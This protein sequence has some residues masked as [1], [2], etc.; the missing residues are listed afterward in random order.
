MNRVEYKGIVAYH[1]GYYV[2]DMIDELDM[3]QEEIS[4][5]LDATPKHV[6]DLINGKSKLTEEFALKLATVFG[7]S[8]QLWLNL[9][10]RYIEKVLEI[11]KIQ[12]LEVECEIAKQIDYSFFVDLGLLPYK[13]KIEEK[14]E[15]LLKYFKVATLKVLSR[16]DFLVQYK[17]AV[18]NIND[19]NVINANAW[20]QSAM[21]I[22]WKIDTKPFDE[23]RLKDSLVEIRTMTVK[24]PID[25]V[26]KLKNILAECGIA[27]VFLP[28]L[29]NSGVN[30]AVKWLSNDKVLIALNDRRKH[31]DFFWFALFHEIGHV[32][33]KRKKLLIVNDGSKLDYDNG[34][35]LAKLEKDANKFAQELL[36]K[37][38]D[39]EEFINDDDFSARRVLMFSNYIGIHPGIVVGRLQRDRIIEFNRLNDLRTKYFITAKE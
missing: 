18:E 35:L 28:N 16:Q 29:K 4:K 25:F 5:R 36:I 10:A 6:S 24:E 27:L 22:G 19:K 9:N 12:G 37:S 34:E 20:I 32:F 14:V 13:R 26:D 17:S 38:T 23:N 21:N 31:A 15:E 33:Q 2:R 30:G 3:T 39:Y 8:T 11:K 7:T 1:P